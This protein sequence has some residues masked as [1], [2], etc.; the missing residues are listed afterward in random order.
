MT[1]ASTPCSTSA[2][3]A[4]AVLPDDRIDVGPHKRGGL[5]QE[6]CGVCAGR[7]DPRTHRLVVD[8]WQ[9]YPGQVLAVG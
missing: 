6:H 5:S 4:P 7:P 2:H 8:H 3:V 9:P 1:I